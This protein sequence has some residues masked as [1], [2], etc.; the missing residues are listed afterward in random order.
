MCPICSPLAP[1]FQMK[2]PIDQRG[3]SANTRVPNI[4]GLA[5]RGRRTVQRL[6]LFIR[7]AA[8][9]LLAGAL[10]ASANA[11]RAATDCLATPDRQA[12]PG[13]HWYYYIDRSTQRKCWYLTQSGAMAPAAAEPASAQSNDS[14]LSRLSS[15]LTAI[16]GP[17]PAPE[18]R[19]AARDGNTGA[20]EAQRRHKVQIA[21]RADQAREPSPPRTSAEPASSPAPSKLDPAAT[22]ALYKEFLQWRAQQLFSAP[23]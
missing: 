8:A 20:S 14:V 13:G 11:A 16:T 2:I 15:A 19:V 10:M 17:A 4:A 12:G 21:K 3:P 18:P 9:T 5:P 7:A 22:E 1:N 6:N 23:Q